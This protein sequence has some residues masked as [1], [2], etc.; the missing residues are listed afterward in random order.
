QLP[1][2]AHRLI[3]PSGLLVVEGP[4]GRL[5]AEVYVGHGAAHA[6]AAERLMS[7]RMAGLTAGAADVLRLGGGIQIRAVRDRWQRELRRGGRPRPQPAIQGRT[8]D[9]GDQDGPAQGRPPRSRAR[10]SWCR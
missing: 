4:I 5:A 3:A 2:L 6:R 9:K 7:A 8:A 10:G 1:I